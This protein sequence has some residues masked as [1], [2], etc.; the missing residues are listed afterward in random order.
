MI[1]HVRMAISRR[2]FALEFRMEAAHV[3][4]DTGRS[5]KLPHLNF[6]LKKAPSGGG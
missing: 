2:K 3:V 1:A 4:I 5:I 6:Q